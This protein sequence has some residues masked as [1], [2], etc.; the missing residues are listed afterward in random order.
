METTRKKSIKNFILILSVLLISF[1]LIDIFIWDS[2]YWRN[3]LGFHPEVESYEQNFGVGNA[4]LKVSIGTRP[5]IVLID[6][7]IHHQLDV[8]ILTCLFE[9][10]SSGLVNGIRLIN[11]TAH[12]YQGTTYKGSFR[13]ECG[14]L[15]C[16]ISNSFSVNPLWVFNI[17]G[18]VRAEIDV[19]GN[20]QIVGFYYSQT[21]I[22][23]ELS[24]DEANIFPL[25]IFGEL[26]VI[27]VLIAVIFIIRRASKPSPPPP[28]T[29][30]EKDT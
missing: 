7:L 19:Q 23:P 30:K 6:E 12:I 29:L 22:I 3:G 8:R 25:I 21:Y 1:T 2:Y 26:I 27:I 14:G 15:I 24:W 5:G 4:T 16:S 9:L 20:S 17:E 28:F 13:T 10:N 18:T 11:A